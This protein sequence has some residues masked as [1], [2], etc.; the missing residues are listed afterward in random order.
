MSNVY[1]SPEDFGLTVIDELSE[2][3]PYQFDILVA[4][5]H[6]DGT[7]YWQ[8]DSGC[9]CPTPFENYGSL[10]ELYKLSDSLYDLRAAVDRHPSSDS[11]KMKFLLAVGA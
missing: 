5:R 1:Y 2:D 9:S 6:T 8:Q 11:E 3:E 4:W 10:A 7:V